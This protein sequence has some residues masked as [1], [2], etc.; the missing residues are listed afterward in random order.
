MAKRVKASD[1]PSTPT[2]GF[3]SDKV[4]GF[5][6]KIEG[7]FED[8]ASEQG[9]YMARCRTIRDSISVVYAEADAL[10]IPRK[11]LK[12]HVDLRRLEQKKK[13]VVEKLDDDEAETFGQVSEALGDF[14]MLPL[15]AAAL[16]RANPDRDAAAVLDGLHG[17]PAR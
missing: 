13:V 15:G 10:G 3:D 2:N 5:V 16:E 12:A 14:A 7:H 6:R 9:A 1:G 8:M 4:A 17:E 11:V